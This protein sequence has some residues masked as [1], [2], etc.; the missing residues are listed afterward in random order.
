M[1]STSAKS[2]WKMLWGRYAGADYFRKSLTL[3]PEL[4]QQ[5]ERGEA[6]SRC[7]APCEHSEIFH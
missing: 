6:R 2:E 1:F 5:S 4:C 7:P 3:R